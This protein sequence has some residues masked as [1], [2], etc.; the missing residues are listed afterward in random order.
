MLLILRLLRRLL[1]LR[2]RLRLWL[3]LSGVRLAALF[4]AT[5]RSNYSDA[6]TIAAKFS[7]GKINWALIVICWSP[8]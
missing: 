5:V 4:A 7:T 1:R 6:G 3:R 2:L 8:L